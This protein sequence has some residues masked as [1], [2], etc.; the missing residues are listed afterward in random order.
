LLPGKLP[1]DHGCPQPAFCRPLRRLQ[2]FHPP[3]RPCTR[4]QALAWTPRSMLSW[5]FSLQ[6]SPTA[7]ERLAFTS[8]PLTCFGEGRGNREGFLPHAPGTSEYHSLRRVALSP[9]R[10]PSFLG[11]PPLSS[12]LTL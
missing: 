2:G 9:E 10:L 6:G 3:A 11:F 1:A 12:F 4:Q 7:L 8:P 5:V